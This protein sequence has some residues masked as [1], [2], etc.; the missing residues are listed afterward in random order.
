[1]M[2]R[3]SSALRQA[4]RDVA[5]GIEPRTRRIPVGLPPEGRTRGQSG[6]VGR[7]EQ[8]D[9]EA[10]MALP[11]LHRVS[12]LMAQG[13]GV[14]DIASILGYGSLSSANAQIQRIRQIMGPQ[15]V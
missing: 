12:E 2:Q 3:G 4:L 9:T 11:T 10:L 7:R 8:I 14:A 15:A 6:Y 13:F 1:M 5:R